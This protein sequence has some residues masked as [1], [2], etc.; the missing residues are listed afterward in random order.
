MF[1]IAR[2]NTIIS[3]SRLGYRDSLSMGVSFVNELFQ[4]MEGF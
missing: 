2:E 1:L 3:F 4:W